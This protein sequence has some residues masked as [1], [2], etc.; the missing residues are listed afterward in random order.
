MVPADVCTRPACLAAVAAA[1]IALGCTRPNTAWRSPV[2]AP[3]SGTGG[4]GGPGDARGDRAP[5]TL[6][7]QD[8]VDGPL[9]PPADA[10]PPDGSSPPVD[11]TSDLPAPVDL[12]PDVAPP[13]DLPPDLPPDTGPPVNLLQNLRVH[14]TF[15]QSSGTTVPDLAG[16][17]TGTLQDGASFVPS[18][19]PNAGTSHHAA[20]F[21]GTDDHMTIDRQNFPSLQS[22]RTISLWI[23]PAVITH[24]EMRTILAF[25]T[26]NESMGIQVG[27]DFGRPAVWRWGTSSGES[28]LRSS[29]ELTSGWHHVLYTYDGTTHRLYVDGTSA[30][31]SNQGGFSGTVGHAF[32]G[33]YDDAELGNEMYVGQLDDVRIYDRVLTPAEIARLAQGQ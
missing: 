13:P 17:N 10:D 15:D 12:P 11:A 26:S 24:T 2:L 1:L 9:V 6:V 7:A 20:R 27:T 14:W 21:Q 32:V 23:L 16:G 19:V 18:G 25:A 28:F 22:I 33:C 5:D 3:D 29:R 8:A 31:S 4:S 30:G